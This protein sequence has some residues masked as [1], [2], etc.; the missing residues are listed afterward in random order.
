MSELPNVLLQEF[1]DERKCAEFLISQRWPNGFVCPE[2]GSCRA[3]R[4]ISRA[5]TF[6][7]RDCRR[8]TS[9]TAGTVM[10]RAKLSLRQWF[11]AAGIFA[12][13]AGIVSVV[14][15][16]RLLDIG[17]H[18]A[19]LLKWKLDRSARYS[20]LE[21]P[22]AVIDREIQLRSGHICTLVVVRDQNSRHIRA[23]VLRDKSFSV[24]EEFITANV[25]V[26]ATLL[27]AD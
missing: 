2:C 22:V 14:Q 3:V 25:T 10:H 6:E 1:S 13:R 19:A 15:L 20:M 7:C 12:D 4:L 9:V 5:D 26:G 21:G 27:C 23:S 11:M 16:S 18:S 17:R 8:Q 24:I